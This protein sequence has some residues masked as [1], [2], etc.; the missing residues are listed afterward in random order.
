MNHPDPNPPT[1]DDIHNA[2]ESGDKPQMPPENL[3]RRPP[4][5][6]ERPKASP[7]DASSAPES[8]DKPEAE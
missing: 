1:K 2:P 7:D 4:M 6:G 5:P 3:L 8:G